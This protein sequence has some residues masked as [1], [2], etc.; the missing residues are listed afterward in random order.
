MHIVVVGSGF[1]GV[2]TALGLANKRDIRVTLVTS[3]PN[4]EYHG[5]LYRSATGRSP[6]E[7]VLPLRDIFARAHNVEIVLDKI[8]SIDPMAKHVGGETGHLYAY[9]KLVLAMGSMV[10]FYGIDGMEEHAY[11]MDNI[12]S[13]ILLRH[14]IVNLLKTNTDPELTVAIVGG[15]PTGIELTGEL[16]FFANKVIDKYKL[17]HQK[18]RITLIEGSP[19]L[20]PAMLP[21]ASQ[22]VLRRLQH[23]GVKVWCGA[24]VSGCNEKKLIVNGTAVRADLIIWTAG[25]C[26][27]PFY[28]QYPRVFQ[29][30]HGKVIVDKFLHPVGHPDIYVIGDNALTRYSGMAQTALH[31]AKFVA[32]HIR[33]NRGRGLHPA[34]R[35]RQSIYV[36]PVGKNWAVV[37]SGNKVRS[38]YAGWLVRRRADLWVFRNFKPYKQAIKTW[39]KGNRW[40]HF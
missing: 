34:Y 13:T 15:G 10:N 26:T 30:K 3:K 5:A 17:H 40:A 21:K 12:E 14:R 9:D 35:V 36:I 2:K 32:S 23:L 16:P 6:L 38:G 33:A 18:L 29:M 1:G 31:D 24:K 22:K 8:V 20:L 7:V 27:V 4:F 28:S 25:S 37:Q 11:T 39:R 19:Q